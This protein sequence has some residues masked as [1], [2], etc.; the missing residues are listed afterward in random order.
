M[1]LCPL[2]HVNYT[3]KCNV[4]Y[5]PSNTKLQLILSS[6]DSCKET[7]SRTKRVF[8]LTHLNGIN[9]VY[10]VHV[11]QSKQTPQYFLF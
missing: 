4:A 1:F 9:S 6:W 7:F 11:I 10:V 5:S 2:K 8:I 3:G